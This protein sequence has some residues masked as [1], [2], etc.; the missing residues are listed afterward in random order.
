MP[1]TAATRLMKSRELFCMPSPE[2]AV[3]ASIS[4]DVFTSL[5]RGIVS[6]ESWQL[7]GSKPAQQ[8]SKQLRERRCVC[9][10]S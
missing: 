5:Q 10:T 9:M 4:A 2:A 7:R 6:S 1:E 8:C 3:A